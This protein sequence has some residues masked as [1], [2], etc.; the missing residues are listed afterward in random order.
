MPKIVAPISFC[1]KIFSV[2]IFN[3]MSCRSK[4]CCLII[5]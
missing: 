4:P 5:L 1:Y 3:C 2:L